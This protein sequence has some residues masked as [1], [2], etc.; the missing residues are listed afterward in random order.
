[1]G[2]LAAPSA[3]PGAGVSRRIATN[4]R[5]MGGTDGGSSLGTVILVLR[6]SLRSARTP[7]L[8]VPELLPPSLFKLARL[9][10][11]V[12]ARHRFGARVREKASVRYRTQSMPCREALVLSL[13]GNDR[14]RPPCG[15][16]V[17]LGREPV[18]GRDRTDSPCGGA[19]PQARSVEMSS[20]VGPALSLACDRRGAR[21]AALDDRWLVGAGSRDGAPAA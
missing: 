20:A 5:G 17:G 12:V 18:A 14:A 11:L 10:N 7:V 2:D 13:A 9:L 6:A 3:A 8:T 19:P 21:R 15:A 16:P 4:T 1:M